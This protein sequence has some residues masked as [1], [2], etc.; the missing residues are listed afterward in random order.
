MPSEKFPIPAREVLS[1]RRLRALSDTVL[2]NVAG[3]ILPG[4]PTEPL[5]ADQDTSTPV[6]DSASHLLP[7]E[8]RVGEPTFK[9][10][11]EARPPLSPGAL[12]PVVAPEGTYPE[13]PPRTL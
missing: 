10:Q 3:E 4:V 13:L 1:E 5:I 11:N 7:Y 9:P 6:E 8:M 12:H 2:S